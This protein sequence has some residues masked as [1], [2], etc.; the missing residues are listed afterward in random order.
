M[1]EGPREIES[2]RESALTFIVDHPGLSDLPY[3]QR[4]NH[5][6][7]LVPHLTVLYPWRPAP[8]SP[9]DLADAARAVRG[10]GPITVRFDHLC[11]FPGGVVYAAPDD[12]SPLIALMHHVWEAFPDHPPY[13]GE[14]SEPV[15][16]ITLDQCDPS[17]LADARAAVQA[18]VAGLMPFEVTF[19][20]LGVL[21]Q[22]TEGRWSVTNALDL[23]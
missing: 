16:H 4:D 10:I 20:A 17:E 23:R 12:P 15:P 13:G 19:H 22:D 3:C 14:F 1:S 5:A 2:T 18:Q 8:L 6:R 21:Q 9:S 11:T 7:G